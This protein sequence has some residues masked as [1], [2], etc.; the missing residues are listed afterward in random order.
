MTV[1]RLHHKRNG[2]DG[3]DIGGNQFSGYTVT[4]G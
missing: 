2:T 4:S 1:A 3:A